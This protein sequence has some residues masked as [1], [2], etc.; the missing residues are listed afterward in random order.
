MGRFGL[1]VGR[2]SSPR[3]TERRPARRAKCARRGV[4]SRRRKADWGAPSLAGGAGLRR[5]A[6]GVPERREGHDS[7]AARSPPEADPGGEPKRGRALR[8]CRRS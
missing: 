2:G 7:R 1:S 5:D 6:E 4:A 8:P 3:G